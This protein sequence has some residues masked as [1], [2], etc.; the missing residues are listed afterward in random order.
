MRNDKERMEFVLNDSNWHR[1]GVEIMGRV[2]L[3]ELEYKS[4]VWYRLDVL[5]PHPISYAVYEPKWDRINFYK[6]HKDTGSMYPVSATSIKDD[7]RRIDSEE[8]KE[9]K[10]Q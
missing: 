10:R 1:V 9:G 4:H 5:Q 7:I 6:I 2:R 3:R 8:K